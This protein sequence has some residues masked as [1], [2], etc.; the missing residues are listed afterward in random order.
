[1]DHAQLMMVL[2]AHD[3]SGFPET[4]LD[5]KYEL[6]E[7]REGDEVS[8]AKTLNLGGFTDW[9]ATKILHYLDGFERREGS[10]VVVCAGEVVSATFASRKLDVSD[11]SSGSLSGLGSQGILDYVVTRPCHRGRGLAK[12]TILRVTK[13][14]FGRGCE[15]V[16]LRTDAWRLPA[17][18]IYLSMGFEPVMHGGDMPSRWQ[19]VFAKL[20]E[21]GENTGN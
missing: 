18:H 15:M 11:S 1:M 7:T 19:D 13:F 4:F 8:W 17:I 10:S 14:L 6:R 20:R 5:P 16:T 12:A 9:D 21:V 3:F 2:K